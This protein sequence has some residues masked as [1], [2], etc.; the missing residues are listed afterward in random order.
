MKL[1]NNCTKTPVKNGDNCT[2]ADYIRAMSDEE[3]ANWL[4]LY[5]VCEELPMFCEDKNGDCPACWLDWL[6]MKGQFGGE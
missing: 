4:A 1:C 5:G 2:N 3:L 6:K